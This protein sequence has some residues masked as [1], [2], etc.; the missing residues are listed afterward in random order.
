[1]FS[2][3][4]FTSFAVSPGFAQS[5]V[6]SEIMYHPL[7]TTDGTVDSDDYEFVEIQNISEAAVDLSGSGFNKFRSRGRPVR[8]RVQQGD[9]LHVL[10]RIDPGRR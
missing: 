10:F 3:A 1:V 6:I 8:L 9:L 5:V 2:A 4:L 7:G